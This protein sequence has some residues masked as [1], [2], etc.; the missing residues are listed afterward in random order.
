MAVLSG[1]DDGAINTCVR[2]RVDLVKTLSVV[3]MTAVRVILYLGSFFYYF[4]SFYFSAI[5]LLIDAAAAQDEVALVSSL[6]PSAN[7]S[8]CP[9]QNVVFNCTV[10][11]TH[12]QGIIEP[13]LIWTYNGQLE[14]RYTNGMTTGAINNDVFSS[15]YYDMGFTVISIATISRVLL[16]QHNKCMVCETGFVSDTKC[17]KIAG[18]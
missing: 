11:R 6:P 17:I 8:I 18:D 2:G 1:F 12:V 3:K 9:G 5:F 7:G 15:V 14:I 16:S 13:T 4:F 10:V